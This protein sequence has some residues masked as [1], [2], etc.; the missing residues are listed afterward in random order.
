MILGLGGHVG[1]WAA[2][3]LPLEQPFLHFTHAGKKASW[4]CFQENYT[5][6]ILILATNFFFPKKDFE[7]NLH[8]NVLESTFSLCNFLFLAYSLECSGDREEFNSCWLILKETECILN[9]LT[10]WERPSY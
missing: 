2:Q 5:L 9:M 8:S 1:I 10:L 6:L 3:A 7:R 4:P